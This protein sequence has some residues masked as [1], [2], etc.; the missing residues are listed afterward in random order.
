MTTSEKSTA[1]KGYALPE[2]AGVSDVW[3]RYG[4]DV[5]RYTTKV[6]SEQTDGRLFQVLI[7]DRR[8]AAAPLHLHHDADETFYVIKGEMSFWVG[9]ERFE[10]KAGDFV[11]GPKGVPHS[12]LAQSDEV[13][14]L[15]T[16][17][18]GGMEGFFSAVGIPVI[19]RE[20]RPVPGPPED[21]EEFARLEKAYNVEVIGPPPT[22]D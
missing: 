4:P 15:I 17:A 2:D 19:A 9:D 13:E 3:W 11:F 21:P 18:P 12:F 10:A 6:A 16:F 8:G 14:F 5:G 20:S 22:L 1:Q 7:K